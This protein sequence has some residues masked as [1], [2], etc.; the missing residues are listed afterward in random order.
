[1]REKGKKG[2]ESQRGRKR[3]GGGEKREREIRLRQAPRKGPDGEICN[4]TLV[5]F[6]LT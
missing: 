5:T 2:K 4:S 6:S 1:M 3:G